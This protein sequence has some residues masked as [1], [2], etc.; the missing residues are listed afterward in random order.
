MK[1]S[2]T[3]DPTSDSKEHAPPTDTSVPLFQ[4]GRIVATP[5][6]LTLLGQYGIPAMALLQRHVRGDWGD[7]GRDDRKAN[8]DAVHDGGR[9]F[10]SYLLN[11]DKVWVITEA[12]GDDGVTRASTCILKPEE[13]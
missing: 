10:S 8:D 13:Y 11:R 7:L 3:L 2:K 6:A 1:V 9:I 4:M 12:T 5:G